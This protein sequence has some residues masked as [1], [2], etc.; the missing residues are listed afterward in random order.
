[1]SIQE[2]TQYENRKNKGKSSQVPSVK[3]HWD[4]K[5]NEIFI[6]LYVEQAKAV[7]RSGT[8][9][10]K[11]GWENVITKFK[12]MTGKAYQRIQTK[13]HWDVLKKDWLLW[14]NLLR[15]ETSIGR[16]TL[17]G[18]ISAF[19]EWYP[20]A[21]KFWLMPLQFS[22]DLDILFSNAVAI[23]EWAYTPSSGVMPNA[24]EAGE[25]FHTPHDAKFDDDVDLEVVH[26]SDLNK[27]TSIKH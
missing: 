22:K 13:N 2:E 23:G 21:T 16:D 10:D 5:S 12:T 18:G 25:E 3:A 17:I 19:D 6:K 24:N 20:D 9:L 15:G 26:H 8:H 1:M 27:K 4:A 7:H 11:V 14:N